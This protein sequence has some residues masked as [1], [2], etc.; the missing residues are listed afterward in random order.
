[1]TPD[2]RRT[3]MFAFGAVLMALGGGRMLLASHC[4]VLAHAALDGEEAGVGGWGLVYEG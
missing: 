3:L 1:M 2:E 4:V